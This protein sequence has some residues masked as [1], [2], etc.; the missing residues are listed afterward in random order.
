MPIYD[1]SC[2]DCGTISEILVTS[3]DDRIIHCPEYNRQNI[4][5]LISASYLVKM[6]KS[7]PVANCCGRQERCTAPPCTSGNNCQRR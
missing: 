5:K 2:K 3:S 4:Y 7:L 1:Y 6:D